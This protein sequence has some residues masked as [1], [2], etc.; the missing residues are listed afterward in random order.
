[1]IGYGNEEFGYKL[2][3]PEKQKIVKSRDIV[4]HE[5]ETIKDM[6]KNVVSTKLT[7]EGVADLTTRQTSSKG[8]IDETDMIG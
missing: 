8:V 2:W 4:F 6:E 5:H 7:Y 3:D 1:M